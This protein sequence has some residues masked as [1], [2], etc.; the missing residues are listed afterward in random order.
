MLPAH[1][2]DVHIPTPGEGQDTGRYNFLCLPFT[3]PVWLRAVPQV[4][5][6]AANQCPARGTVL[7]KFPCCPT[8]ALPSPRVQTSSQRNACC[9]LCCSQSLT[10]TEE[11]AS[12]AAQQGRAWAS[13]ILHGSGQSFRPETPWEQVSRSRFHIWLCFCLQPTTVNL[14]DASDLT[15]T[16]LGET[17][18]ILQA[19]SVIIYCKSSSQFLYKVKEDI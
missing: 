12:P 4:M 6:K 7:V 5:R 15:D 3:Q 11:D 19:C 10:N 2:Q 17:V 1:Q 14:S 9:M 8:E 18:I 16:P 13:W